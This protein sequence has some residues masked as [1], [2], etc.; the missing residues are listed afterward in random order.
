M[1]NDCL[2]TKLKSVVDNDNLSYLGAIMC[3]INEEENP[4]PS[5][6]RITVRADGGDVELEIIEGQAHFTNSSG[7]SDLGKSS[8]IVA[9]G[10]QYLYLSNHAGKL[11]IKNKYHISEIQTPQAGTVLSINTKQLENI[12]A[13][14]G[15]LYLSIQGGKM[16]GNLSDFKTSARL[17]TLDFSYT[18]SLSGGL[19]EDLEVVNTLRLG[20]TSTAIDGKKMNIIPHTITLQHSSALGEVTDFVDKDSVDVR[21]QGTRITGSAESGFE[22]IWSEG[23][24]TGSMIL[25]VGE[26]Q[27][28]KGS[29]SSGNVLNATFDEY[30]IT[31]TNSSNVTVATYNGSSWTY[32]S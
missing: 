2:V 5:N 8:T 25:Q 12:G 26:P 31:I 15:Y 18:S 16:V 29:V 24:R 6:R 4:T 10:S 23:K 3:T 27:T 1:A 13:S 11:L 19:N 17:T 30:G 9:G 20:N 7:S 21:I 22:K 14:V 32:N 28:W